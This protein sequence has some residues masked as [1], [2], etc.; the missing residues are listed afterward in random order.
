M[1]FVA[2]AEQNPISDQDTAQPA[3]NSMRRKRE[4]E[5]ESE[6]MRRV[7]PMSIVSY[8]YY[9]TISLV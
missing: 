3:M 4:R 1:A 2:R 7:S 8:I 6:R 5:R 9:T